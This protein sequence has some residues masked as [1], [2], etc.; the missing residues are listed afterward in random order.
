MHYPINYTWRQCQTNKTKK[1]IHTFYTI[2]TRFPIRGPTGRFPAI[3]PTVKTNTRESA[4]TGE[5]AGKRESGN[6]GNRGKAI[7]A[8]QQI[9][10]ISSPSFKKSL[11]QVTCIKRLHAMRKT[12]CHESA[13][14]RLNTSISCV[15]SSL[16]LRKSL[17]FNAIM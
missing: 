2:E 6:R 8:N 7:D 16:Q 3:W 15:E 17:L 12:A 10:C 1:C 14:I 4:G 13:R 11:L 9:Q 5:S